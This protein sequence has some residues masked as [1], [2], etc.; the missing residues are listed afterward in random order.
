MESTPFKEAIKTIE[1]KKNKLRSSRHLPINSKLDIDIDYALE[2]VIVQLEAIQGYIGGDIVYVPINWWNHFKK[3]VFPEWL[4]DIFPVSY[5]T[6]EAKALLPEFAIRNEK[7][8]LGQ[9][10]YVFEPGGDFISE[11]KRLDNSTDQS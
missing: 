10:I 2:M 7:D 4:L 9:K 6:Y 5:K 8:I 11:S 3:E 1:I